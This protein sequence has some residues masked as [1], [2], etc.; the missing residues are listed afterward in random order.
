M[1]GTAMTERIVSDFTPKYAVVTMSAPQMRM[2]GV[3][4]R[5]NTWLMGSASI[6]T[7]T[8]NQPTCV[9]PR[10]PETR[11]EPFSPNA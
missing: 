2:T 8:P 7:L 3:T 10:M 11:Y 6:T 5:P 1:A 4:S 9:R